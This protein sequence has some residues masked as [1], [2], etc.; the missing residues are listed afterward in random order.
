LAYR[1]H[2]KV[3]HEF[4]F[5]QTIHIIYHF[6]ISDSLGACIDE[7]L[8]PR[9]F[10]ELDKGNLNIYGLE[11]GNLNIP[12]IGNGIFG[13]EVTQDAHFNIKEGRALMSALPFAPIVSVARNQEKMKEVSVVDYL[14]GLV[15]RIQCFG[16]YHVKYLYYVSIL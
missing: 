5:N 7:N 12:Y 15:S 16:D 4:E 3:N 13:M 8:S 2:K 1:S 10:S 9:I 14:N 11:D 6:W